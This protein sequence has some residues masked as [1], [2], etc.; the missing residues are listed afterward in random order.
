MS[1]LRNSDEQILWKDLF[2][3]ASDYNIYRDRIVSGQAR[4]S[5]DSRLNEKHTFR[6]SSNE[7]RI[8]FVVRKRFKVHKSQSNDVIRA[9]KNRAINTTH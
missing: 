6:I 5:I 7:Q 8:Y 2:N 1:P 3:L 4:D 9:R